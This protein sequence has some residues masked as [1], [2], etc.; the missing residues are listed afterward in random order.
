MGVHIL[1]GKEGNA[2][3][4]CST[5][6]WA[7]GPIMGSTEKAEAFL[8]FLDPTDPRELADKDLE[9]RYSEFICGNV[10][11]CGALR[12]EYDRDKRL[13]EMGIRECTCPND[14]GDCPFCEGT[15]ALESWKPE[16]GERFVCFA[17]G[18][19]EKKRRGGGDGIS[20]G[21]KG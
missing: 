20:V 18:R 4:Y 1:E 3:F 21:N 14:E 6:D 5:T 15:R 10:C 8:K 19:R 16:P 9:H 13:A 2:A 7:F 12:D 17:C 11:E